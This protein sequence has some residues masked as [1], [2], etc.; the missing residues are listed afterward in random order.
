MSQPDLGPGA[1][2]AER[3]PSAPANTT[4]VPLPGPSSDQVTRQ[5][6]GASLFG[7]AGP[8]ALLGLSALITAAALRLEDV[9]AGRLA[10][11]TEADGAAV[12]GGVSR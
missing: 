2:R 5:G 3:P 7:G 12:R 6:V 9:L 4:T 1:T 8:V 11:I 10:T